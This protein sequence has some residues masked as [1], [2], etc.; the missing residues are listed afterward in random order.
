MITKTI[1]TLNV[2]R[3]AP[4]IRRITRPFL[5]HWAR[6][7]GAEIVDIRR[8]KFPDWPVTYEKLQ[9][10]RLAQKI[11]SDWNIYVDS[12]ALIHPETPDFTLV[13]PSDTVCHWGADRAIARW[14]FDDYFRRDARNI[15]SCNWF[16]IASQW[17]LDLWRPI[18]D[19]TPKE[20]VANIRPRIA[21]L[22]AGIMAEHL[23]DDYVLS[24][25]IA[26]FGLKF[27][28]IK[29]ILP[30]IGLGG[31]EYFYHQYMITAKKKLRCLEAQAKAWVGDSLWP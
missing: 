31:Q 20:A 18:D 23:I 30:R 3:Y 17:C 22:T 13:L 16:T 11:G 24:R 4:R 12:D 1:F 21:E 26:R 25:N 10:H 28:T 27:T 14:I 15:S 8:R 5:E 19:L 6:K 2:N 7:I 9:I 29:D